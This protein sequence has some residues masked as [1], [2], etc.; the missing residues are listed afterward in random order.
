LGRLILLSSVCPLGSAERK[1][2]MSEVLNTVRLSYSGDP[3]STVQGW[4]FALCD[5]LTFEWGENIAGYTP[6]PFGP[7]EDA[8]E[9][10]ELVESSV[11]PEDAL[12]ALKILDRAREIIRIE[13]LDY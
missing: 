8:W 10:E 2:N 4:R 5:Y 3:F 7:D 6:S 1:D 9:Y 12:Y 11:S 13:G